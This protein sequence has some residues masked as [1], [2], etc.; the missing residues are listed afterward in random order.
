METK[1]IIDLFFIFHPL[2][3]YIMLKEYVM[4]P[5][6]G[7]INICG[8]WIYDIDMIKFSWI[9]I[10]YPI[11]LYRAFGLSIIYFN[12]QL[13]YTFVVL[14]ISWVGFFRKEY[15]TEYFLM[16]FLFSAFLSEYWE[17]PF[18]LNN[19]I[20][21]GFSIPQYT[22]VLGKVTKLSMGVLGLNYMKKL[23]LNSD[24]TTLFLIAGIFVFTLLR[25]HVFNGSYAGNSFLLW[26][27][28][29]VCFLVLYL[30]IVF[31]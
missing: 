10:F 5:L 23:G 17:I 3:L 7:G 19:G 20:F 21:Y 29:I 24:R 2:I 16:G 4:E 27:F 22:E 12:V 11:I 26:G 8:M 1:L 6:K 13:Y 28:R 30:N 15:H 9:Y 14:I 18:Y 31:K 25:F